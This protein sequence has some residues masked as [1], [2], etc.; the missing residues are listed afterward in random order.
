MSRLTSRRSEGFSLVETICASL[1]L[2]VGLVGIVEAITLSLTTSKECERYTQSVLLAAGHL[3]E[4]RAT[5]TLSAG[6]ESGDFGELFPLYSWSQTVTETSLDGLYEVT[7]VVEIKKDETKS[8]SFY[9]LKTL[10]FDMPYALDREEE[11]ETAPTSGDSAS[12]MR[13]ER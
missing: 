7:V 6:E 11:L 8:E 9:E 10:L 1:I 2:G 5:G 12:P 3:E 13:N 4:L